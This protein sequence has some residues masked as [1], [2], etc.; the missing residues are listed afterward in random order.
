[1]KYKN[2]KPCPCQ[3][4]AIY[5]IHDAECLPHWGV[6]RLAGFYLVSTLAAGFAA[7]I[8]YGLTKMNGMR[9]LAGWRWIFIVVRFQ[10][11]SIQ[12]PTDID[13]APACRKGCSPALP[14]SA[15]TS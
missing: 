4:E 3:F 7:V 8:T 15:H 5:N 11:S 14:P 9:G 13:P 10:P 2:G 6:S 12:F 1:M